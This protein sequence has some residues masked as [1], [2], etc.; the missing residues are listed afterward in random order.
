MGMSSSQTASGPTCLPVSSQSALAG[1]ANQ[2]IQ[3][4]EARGDGAQNQ[5]PESSMNQNAGSVFTEGHWSPIP[6]NLRERV[7]IK[8]NNWLLALEFIL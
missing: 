6:I 3:N 4:P 5:G 7:F 1:P 8:S 2:D